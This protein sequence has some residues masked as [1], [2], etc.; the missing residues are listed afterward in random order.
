MLRIAIYMAL[1]AELFHEK[2]G[3]Y[4]MRGMDG[5]TACKLADYPHVLYW[6]SFAFPIKSS[7]R[8]AI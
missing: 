4:P 1:R 7:A 5:L 6:R 3:I 2:H 8:S